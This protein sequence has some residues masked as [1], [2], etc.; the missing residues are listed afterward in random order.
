M[1]WPVMLL[2]RWL[3]SSPPRRA[4]LRN[5]RAMQSGRKLM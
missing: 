1:H 4:L 5:W 2:L 3:P